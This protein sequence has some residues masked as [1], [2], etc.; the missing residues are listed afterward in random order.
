MRAGLLLWYRIYVTLTVCATLY[1][2]KPD[3]TVKIQFNTK[4]LGE[5]CPWSLQSENLLKQLSLEW[6][7]VDTNDNMENVLTLPHFTEV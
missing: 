6:E 5:P 7:D 2:V 3:S 4:E 1:S